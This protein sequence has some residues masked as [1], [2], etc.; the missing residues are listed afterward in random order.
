M[1]NI[2]PYLDNITVAGRTQK[3]HDAGVKSFLEAIRRNNFTLNESK[4]VSSVD[5]IKILGYLVKNGCIKPDP[6]RLRSL[7]DFP[8]PANLKQLKSVLGMF[9]NYAKR[10]DDFADKVRL[11]TNAKTFPIDRNIDALSSFQS[12]TL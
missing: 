3:E 11:S 1:K 7:R 2:F 6:D 12:L 5:S 10:I 4:T 8:P 9:A